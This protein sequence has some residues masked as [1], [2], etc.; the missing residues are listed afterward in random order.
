MDWEIILK[1]L[2]FVAIGVLLLWVG[3][4]NWKRRD[5]EAIPWIE[6]RIIADSGEEY[7]PRTRFDRISRR[8]QAG[9]GLIFGLFFVFIGINAALLG[10]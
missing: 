5:S 1:G 8:I 10:V 2:S 9:L 7:L 3:W 4:N 6:Q